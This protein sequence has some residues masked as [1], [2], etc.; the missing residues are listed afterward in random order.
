M[1]EEGIKKTQNDMIYIGCPIPFDTDE[2]L[3][4]LEELLEAAYKNQS[5]IKERVQ[6]VVKTY[7]PEM[8]T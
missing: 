8:G 5:D 7:K 3:K 4:Q 6:R 1:A 2:F